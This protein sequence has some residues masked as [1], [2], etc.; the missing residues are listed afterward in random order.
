MSAIIHT[1][2]DAENEPCFGDAD[3]FLRGFG[4]SFTWD[5]PDDFSLKDVQG[6]VFFVYDEQNSPR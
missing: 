6:A 4:V 3:S 5:Y 2:A 1:R